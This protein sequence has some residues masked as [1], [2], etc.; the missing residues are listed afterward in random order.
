MYIHILPFNISIIVVVSSGSKS[1][2]SYILKTTNLNC[3]YHM[4][5]EQFQSYLVLTV[6]IA[7]CWNQFD[8]IVSEPFRSY[9]VGTVP[10]LWCQ[11]HSDLI[12]SE[13]F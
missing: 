10:I 1:Q 2:I 4:M 5:S 11:N 6:P 3:S 8:L 7:Y 13:P 12:V 9:G